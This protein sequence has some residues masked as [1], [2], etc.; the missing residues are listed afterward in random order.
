MKI[1]KIRKGFHSSLHPIK[2]HKDKKAISFDV[3][4]D[5]NCRYDLESNDQY[6][7]NKLYGISWGYHMKNSFRI[8]WN[9]DLLRDHINLW[10]YTH[11]N[12]VIEA[13]YIDFVPTDYNLKID[14]FFNREKNN[15]IIK[16]LNQEKT[17]AFKFPENKWGYYLWPY[18]GGNR[19]SPH[20]ITIKLKE[21]EIH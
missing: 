14:V 5:P 19:R 1:F 4:F 12:G 2:L 8:G 13:E 20:T 10:S 21:N 15:I 6:D 3:S 11:N 17:I 7:I 18:F 9:W 16:W